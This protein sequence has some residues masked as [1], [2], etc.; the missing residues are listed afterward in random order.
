M[1]VVLLRSHET[2]HDTALPL[3]RRRRRAPLALGT[4]LPLQASR[5]ASRLTTPSNP[6]AGGDAPRGAA[7]SERCDCSSLQ[8]QSAS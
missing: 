8:S 4:R 5:Q 2:C 6:V 3:P 1:R 7:C